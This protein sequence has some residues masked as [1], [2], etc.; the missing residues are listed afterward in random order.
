[1]AAVA[2]DTPRYKSLDLWRGVA[3]LGVVLYHATLW[4]AHDLIGRPDTAA[5]WLL[6]G[7]TVLSHGVTLFFV[8]SGYCVTGAAAACARDGGVRRFIERRLRRIYPPYWIAMVAT[9]AIVVILDLVGVGSLAAE[10]LPPEQLTVIAHPATLNVWQWLGNLSLTET[11]RTRFIWRGGE[12]YV[13]GPSWTLSYEEQFYAVTA[14]LLLLAAGVNRRY[15]VAAT[16][17]TAL[18]CATMWWVS[19]RRTHGLFLDGQWLLFAAGVAVYFDLH[20]ATRVW[21][22]LTRVAL[23]IPLLMWAF[24]HGRPSMALAGGFALLLIGLWRWD[25]VSQA[26]GLR[27]LR[28]FGLMS[29]SV[30]L[31]HWPVAK[32]VGVA[33]YRSGLTSPQSALAVTVPVVVV[34]SVAVGAT[35]YWLVE[36]HFVG[37]GPS[38]SGIAT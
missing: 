31:L 9:L 20:Q 28:Q 15:F 37:R 17:M 38:P 14:L 29:Y 7:T 10:P 24:W 36:R 8:I 32:I 16:G 34:L 1:M 21:R 30:Y 33:L 19:Q 5:E 26:P 3:C 2:T 6:R 22:I 18:V 25:H 12:R 35:F 23:G 4:P 27:P 13:L 11:W